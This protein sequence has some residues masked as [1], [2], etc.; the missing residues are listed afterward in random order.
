MLHKLYSVPL[1]TSFCLLNIG[2]GMCADEDSHPANTP[3]LSYTAPPEVK[4]VSKAVLIA[5]IDAFL[6]H[7]KPGSNFIDLGDHSIYAPDLIMYRKYL[8]QGYA[9]PSQFEGRFQRS[10]KLTTSK[11]E[12]FRTAFGASNYYVSPVPQNPSLV[13]QPWT[14]GI[15]YYKLNF[16][17]Q[18]QNSQGQTKEAVFLAACREW[19]AVANIKFVP[20]TGNQDGP[21][22]LDVKISGDRNHAY[23]GQINRGAGPDG[24][25]LGQIFE[26][27]NWQQDVVLHELGH[28][29]G[30]IHEHQRADRDEHIFVNNGE[31]G[32]PSNIKT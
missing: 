9:P 21:S 19:E 14:N 24:Q 30:F 28:A 18:T 17:D 32:R 13:S 29:L 25:Y 8:T 27:N 11:R 3:T 10:T 12:G 2:V 31:N 16:Q 6:S 7:V 5:R 23:T 4:P 20:W 22:Y 15:V 26:I 1:V